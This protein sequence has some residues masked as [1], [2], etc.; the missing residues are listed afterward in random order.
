MEEKKM[1][2]HAIGIVEFDS[3][4][5]GYRVTNLMLK[6]MN[7]EGFEDKIIAR[8]KYVA[9]LIDTYERV[10]SA[11]SFAVASEDNHIVDFALIGN[12]HEDL[13]SYIGNK[14]EIDFD[15]IVDLA[16][17]KTE[18]FSSCMEKANIILHFANVRLIDINYSDS[19]NGECLITLQGNTSNLMASIEKLGM[20]ELVL[21]SDIRLLKRIL[22]RGGYN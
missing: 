21:R 9:I 4:S 16:V 3:V 14:R 18:T 5:V 7:I 20:G 13:Q 11:V 10:E 19:L 6:N 1:G 8:G 2:K 17:V 15:S 22:E 12:M